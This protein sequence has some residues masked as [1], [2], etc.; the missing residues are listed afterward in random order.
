MNLQPF[1]CLFSISR[2]R[3]YIRYDRLNFELNFCESISRVLMRVE[4]FA[5]EN[6]SDNKGPN[7]NIFFITFD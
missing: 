3:N 2:E 4:G 5:H 1:F 6:R 7:V